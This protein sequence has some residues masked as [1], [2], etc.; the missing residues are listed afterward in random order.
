MRAAFVHLFNELAQKRVSKRPHHFYE[1]NRVE[2][3]V[4]TR[5]EY[6]NAR[7]KALTTDPRVTKPI[8][9]DTVIKLL[10]S[11]N[12]KYVEN[13]I[14]TATD[15]NN[16]L[17]TATFMGITSKNY[18]YIKIFSKTW[19]VFSTMGRLD[20]IPYQIDHTILHESKHVFTH[21]I[22]HYKGYDDEI[23]DMGFI[24]GY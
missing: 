4:M 22:N 8:F 24:Y 18:D 7:A 10:N 14:N 13:S 23:G 3:K 15:E 9:V 19:D 17:V 16:N 5:Q 11:N 21:N 12:I 1:I 6:V 2:F 20:M